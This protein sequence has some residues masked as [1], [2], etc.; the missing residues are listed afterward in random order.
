[1]GEGEFQFLNGFPVQ[2]GQDTQETVTLQGTVEIQHGTTQQFS[3]WQ[4]AIQ[5][6]E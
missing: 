5:Q 2:T 1:L 3:F 4:K 6:Q